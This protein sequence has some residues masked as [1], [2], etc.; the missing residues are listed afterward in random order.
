ML[1]SLVGIDL[2]ALLAPIPNGPP[3]GIDL[4]RDFSPTSLYFRLRDARSEA[5]DAERQADAPDPSVKQTI[6]WPEQWRTIELLAVEALTTR[7]KDLE[8]A[9]WL[10]EALVRSSGLAGLTAAA[11]IL[12]GLVDAYWDDLFPM[13]DEDGLET[14]VAP[15]AGL[16]GQGVDG[17][18]M[19]PLRKIELM[20]RPD[21]TAFYF[22]QYEETLDLAGLADGQR[23]QQKLEAGDQFERDARAAGREHWSALRQ[24]ITQALAAWTA[25]GQS[26]DNRAARASPSTGRVRDLLQAME[27]ITQ[28]FAPAAAAASEPLG[29]AIPGAA[30][31]GVGG[32]EFIV[33]QGR[34]DGRE[35]ALAQLGEIAAWFKRNEPHSPLAYTLEEAARRG[36]M[37]WPQLL[38][39]LIP[40]ETGRHALLT[41][42]G[43]KPI[44]ES[45]G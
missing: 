27:A 32:T 35:Q 26:L 3:T 38:E 13:P 21:K 11:R 31:S 34:I 30:A 43:I 41:S 22:W 15:L 2:D 25:L 1:T 12:T 24:E 7:A 18:L 40:D 17:T 9:A 44:S 20:R 28:R 10:T 8:I 33:P 45:G 5:R 29:V 19:Q 42:L 6:A 36:R 4:R 14:R 37:S 16:S 39:E 23:R